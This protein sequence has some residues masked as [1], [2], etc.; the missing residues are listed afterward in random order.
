MCHNK[1]NVETFKTKTRLNET[2][3]GKSWRKLHFCTFLSYHVGLFWA[4]FAKQ[5]L[6]LSQELSDI[7]IYCIKSGGILFSSIRVSLQQKLT[8]MRQILPL[9]LLLILF[10]L[11]K[12]WWD[13]SCTWCW[14]AVSDSLKS[15]LLNH[16]VCEDWRS[17]QD[18][19]VA[20]FSALSCGRSQS[21]WEVSVW[22]ADV[23]PGC[24]HAAVFR[25]TL[26]CQTEHVCHNMSLFP[27]INTCNSR[28][29]RWDW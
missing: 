16:D 6:N 26:F 2:K 29:F 17:E 3:L 7:A 15:F 18:L 10:S 20:Y 24:A 12:S 21:W 14:S 9:F 5:F 11:P 4:V 28:A 25:P 19:L 23:E 13:L 8:N 27:L 22:N 1:T